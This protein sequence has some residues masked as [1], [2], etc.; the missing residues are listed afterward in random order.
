MALPILHTPDGRKPW[1][2]QA[3]PGGLGLGLA[4][5]RVHELCGPAR[6]TL[7]AMIL[8]QSEGPVLWIG[9]G[10]VAERIYPPGLE[11]W[12]DPGRFDVNPESDLCSAKYCEAYNTDLC[13]VSRI[14]EQM[15]LGK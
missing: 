9:P 8:G 11:E 13:P 3:L 5:G 14:K 10:W 2:V 15:R 4:R 1:P 12:A 6:W 7:A